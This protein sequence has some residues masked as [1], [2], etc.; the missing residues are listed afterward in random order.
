MK[1]YEPSTPRTAFGLAAVALT[2]LTISLG[3]VLPSIGNDNRD[4]AQLAVTTPV[5]T[6]GAAAVDVRYIEP[7]D[8]VAYR[9]REVTSAQIRSVQQR[10]KEQG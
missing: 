8:V 4:D 1:R 3:V 7:V 10:R 9:T 5:G 6:P 2:V